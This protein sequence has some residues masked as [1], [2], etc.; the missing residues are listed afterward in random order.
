MITSNLRVLLEGD[1][2]L[3]PLDHSQGA[4]CNARK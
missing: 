3:Q 4:L 2:D 1:R